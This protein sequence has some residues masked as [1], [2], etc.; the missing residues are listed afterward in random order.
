M[1]DHLNIE[2]DGDGDAIVDRPLIISLYHARETTL[3]DVGLQV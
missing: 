2:I 3:T 1:K